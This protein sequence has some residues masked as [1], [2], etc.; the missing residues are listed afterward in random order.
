MGQAMCDGQPEAGTAKLAL[1][2]AID[3]FVVLEHHVELL[4][5]NPNASIFYRKAKPGAPIIGL[6]L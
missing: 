3:L 4:R 5:S 1:G 6:H 2:T